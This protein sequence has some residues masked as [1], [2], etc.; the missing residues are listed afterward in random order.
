MENETNTVTIKSYT[1]EDYRQCQ[2]ILLNGV[3]IWESGD[4]AQDCPED[5]T[6]SRDMTNAFEIMDIVATLK[7]KEYQVVTIKCKEREEYEKDL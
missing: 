1:D 6:L 4:L 3:A 7:G 2:K 5:A